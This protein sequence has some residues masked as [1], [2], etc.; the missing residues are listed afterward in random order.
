MHVQ[1][2]LS[3]RRQPSRGSTLFVANVGAAPP[4]QLRPV[5]RAQ[6]C[7][8]QVQQEIAEHL[9]YSLLDLPPQPGRRS[10]R[11]RVAVGR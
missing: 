1:V 11:P 2:Q 8:A 3:R 4:R 7:A 6:V 9:D 5:L 10:R